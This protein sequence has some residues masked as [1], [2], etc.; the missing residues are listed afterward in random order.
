[1]SFCTF[2]RSNWISFFICPDCYFTLFWCWWSFLEDMYCISIFIY[3]CSYKF[4]SWYHS[5]SFCT[6][7]RSNWSSFFIC[8]D[9]YFTLF[10]CWWCFLSIYMNC[11]SIFI[12]L[13]F[14]ESIL[15]NIFLIC[16]SFFWWFNFFTIF[17]NKFCNYFMVNIINICCTFC[18][19]TFFNRYF[20]YF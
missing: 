3:C 12:F 18:K 19:F 1:M 13:R 7:F 9:C 5:M 4:I 10:W 14:F 8:P 17:I 6:F 2:F 20:W 11:V 16:S 15:W